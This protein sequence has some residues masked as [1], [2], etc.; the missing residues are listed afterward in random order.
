MLPPELQLVVEEITWHTV[1]HRPNTLCHALLGIRHG[2]FRAV[3]VA[4]AGLD[5]AMEEWEKEEWVPFSA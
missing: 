4:E 5:P 3:I 2:H 1:W